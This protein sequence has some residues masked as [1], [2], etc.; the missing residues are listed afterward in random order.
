MAGFASAIRRSLL[1]AIDDLRRTH[2][3]IEVRILEY[4]PLEA[5]FTPERAMAPG[6][7]AL[8]GDKPAACGISD[9]RRNIVAQVH[10]ET[11]DVA[12]A[13]AASDAS[14]SA[15]FTTQRVQHVSLE[16]HGGLAWFDDS[17]VLNVRSSTQVPFLVKRTLER[18]FSL[19]AGTVRVVA[20]RVGGGFGG[21]QEVL[22]E[23]VLAL[24]ALRF[25]RPVS[26]EFTRSEVFTATTT[27]HPFR[28]GVAVG[29]MRDGT[30]T[31]LSIDVLTDTT[32]DGEVA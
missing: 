1:P 6:A 21:K 20:G 25:R 28:V 17:A 30:L 5:V 19:P 4:E 16:T 26:L 15:V 8:H 23:D 27:R 7:T 18:I 11:G 13:L 9:A 29:G 3:G 2:P 31:A 22:V 12:A 24:A 14:Y 10:Q 32:T